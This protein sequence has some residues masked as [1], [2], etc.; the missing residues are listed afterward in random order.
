[1]V[2]SIAPPTLYAIYC[3]GVFLKLILTAQIVAISKLQYEGGKHCGETI[4]ITAKGKTAQATIMDEVSSHV[5]DL[6]FFFTNAR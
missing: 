1:M 3:Q 6:V 4:T 2:T 5:L